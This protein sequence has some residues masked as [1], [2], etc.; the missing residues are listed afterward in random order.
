VHNIAPAETVALAPLHVALETPASE[1][2]TVAATV[3][4]LVDTI[5]PFVGELNACTCGHSR[6]LSNNE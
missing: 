1:S 5:A 3:T 6:D 4:P 2:L